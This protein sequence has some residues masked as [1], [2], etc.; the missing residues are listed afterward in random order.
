MM[1]LSEAVK[2]RAPVAM[3]LILGVTACAPAVPESGPGF[4]DYNSYMRER[5]AGGTGSASNGSYGAGY[6]SNSGYGQSSSD[7]FSAAG[8]SAALDRAQGIGSSSSTESTTPAYSDP[9]GA[10]IGGTGA[11]GT[12][13]RGN[14]PAGIKEES[15]EMVHAP[16]HAG[17][18]DEQDFSA[19]SSRETI[20]SDKERIAR[21]RAQYEVIQPGALP[22][23]TGKEGPNI[24][25]YA[26]Q[27]NHPVGA[28]MYSRSSWGIR[29][30]AANCAKFAS[31][32]L[33]QEWFLANGGPEKD[34]RGLDPDGDGYA[35]SWDPTPFR[36]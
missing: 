3:L 35:C 7:G 10:I 25:Q 12:R 8:A 11:S 33:A 20:A 9:Q 23:R 32:D 15:G 18:S 14:A 31:P 19:V 26:L 4:Q 27:S 36:N 29:N 22:Q 5:A 24:V 6:G 30:S 28:Q 13:A 21:N 34:K 16:G 1:N 2:M 17:M